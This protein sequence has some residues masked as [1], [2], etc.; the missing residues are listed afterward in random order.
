MTFHWIYNRIYSL[1]SKLIKIFLRFSF[2]QNFPHTCDSIQLS[3]EFE[4]LFLYLKD[5]VQLVLSHPS[6]LFTCPEFAEI[7]LA[8]FL[9][10][11][12]VSFTITS[13][14]KLRTSQSNRAI[15]LKLSS[16]LLEPASSA[17]SCNLPD[18]E[19]MK[20]AFRYS[21]GRSTPRF[22]REGWFGEN[23]ICVSVQFWAIDTTFLPRGL[24]RRKWNLRFGTVL[25]DRRRVFSERVD[26]RLTL[27]IPPGGIE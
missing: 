4:R 25:G 9:E 13:E 5:S 1:A 12:S 22:Y 2:L 8:H 18:R 11:L 26:F 16:L 17:S 7:Q 24:I 19:K 27:P 3:T 6:L 15:V 21:F 14:A 10:L 23:E 20:F